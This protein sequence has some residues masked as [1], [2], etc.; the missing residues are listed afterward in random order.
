LIVANEAAPIPL[1][2]G[3]RTNSGADVGAPRGEA[4]VARVNTLQA[5]L[6]PAIRV[7]PADP[8]VARTTTGPVVDVTPQYLLQDIGRGSLVRHDGFAF[9]P[10]GPHGFCD[11]VSVGDV[12]TVRYANGIGEILEPQRAEIEHDRAS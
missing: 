12:V 11:A 6:S 1:E 9:T 4:H 3:W 5:P 10:K 8:S 7:T 2:D